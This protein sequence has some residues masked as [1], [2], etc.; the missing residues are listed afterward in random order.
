MK[1]N[2]IKALDYQAQGERLFLT[3]AE[4]SLEQI[5]GMDTALLRIT[6]DD[7]DLVEAFSG[8]R[9]A[10]VTYEAA[11]GTFLAVLEQGAGDTTAA[12]LAALTDALTAAEE[13]NKELQIQMNEQADALIELAGLLTEEGA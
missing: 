3:L 9:V 5:T 8:Y 4:T 13:Q 12:A 7:G 2:G 11:D 6:T 10:R 1:S